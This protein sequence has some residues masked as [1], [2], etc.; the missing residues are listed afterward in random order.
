MAIITFSDKVSEDI[1]NGRISKQTQRRLPAELHLKAQIK[2][3]RLAAATS[4][5]D[6]IE[7]R[8][9]RLEALKGNRAHQYS[10]RINDQIGRA[11][12]RERV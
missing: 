7:L 3:A 2:L 9:N 5:N 6:L 4:L 12:C 1:C 10:M 11:S 8:G